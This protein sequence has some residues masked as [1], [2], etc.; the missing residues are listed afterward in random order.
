MTARDM[1][2]PW[3]RCGALRRELALLGER[4]LL[5]PLPDLPA[6]RPD[7]PCPA[8]CDCVSLLV[9]PGKLAGELGDGALFVLEDWARGW[10]QWAEAALGASG[11]VVREMLGHDHRS[12]VCLRTPG[13]GDFTAEAAEAGRCAGL[14][15]RWLDIDLDH[16]AASLTA[17]VPGRTAP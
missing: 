6:Y 5:P 17:A 9:P 10:S 11:D 1:A 7:R 13:S 12:L 2:V 14:P 15:V 4:G 8:G 3:P 16:L